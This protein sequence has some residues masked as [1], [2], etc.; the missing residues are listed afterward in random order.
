[1]DGEDVTRARPLPGAIAA[2][3][4]GDTVRLTIERDGRR[5][6]IEVTLGA[7]SGTEEPGDK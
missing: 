7:W 3:E 6:E 5:Q 4:P 2:H 1:V